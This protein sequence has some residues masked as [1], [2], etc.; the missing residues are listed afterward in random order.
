MRVHIG[1]DSLA[2]LSLD[3][4]M[5]AI[6]DGAPGY[7]TGCFTGQYPIEV[8]ETPQKLSFEGVLS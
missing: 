5:R 3:G 7:C 6:S 8:S 1:A 2:F 4:M